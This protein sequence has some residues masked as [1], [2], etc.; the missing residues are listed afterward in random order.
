MDGGCSLWLP[1]EILCASVGAA[2]ARVSSQDLRRL[3]MSRCVATTSACQ[4]TSDSG[5]PST[6]HSL[7]LAHEDPRCPDG[8][9]EGLPR[10]QSLPST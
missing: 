1:R 10:P 5:R 6:P 4:R 2:A 8:D 3:L 7:A 9:L